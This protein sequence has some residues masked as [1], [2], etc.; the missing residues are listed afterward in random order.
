M[1]DKFTKVTKTGYGKRLGN[2]LKG[3]LVGV[4]LFFASFAVLYWNEGR[5][6]V[7][8]IAATATPIDAMSQADSAYEGMLVSATGKVSSTEQIGDGLY[9]LPGDYLVVSRS[10][11]MFAWVE[12]TS[13]E[14]ETEWGGSETETTTYDYV[15]KWTSMPSSS[16]GFEYPEDHYNPEMTIENE[17]YSVE[18]GKVGT[19]ELD[20]DKIS[21]AG[22]DSLSLEH[23][24]LTGVSAEA[25]EKEEVVE[26]VG[27]FTY[28]ELEEAEYEYEVIEEYGE[29][30]GSDE[31]VALVGDYI[32]IGEGT[33]NSPEV[34]DTRVSYTALENNVDMTVYGKQSGQKIVTHVDEKTGKS[35]YRMF[36]G[37]PEEAVV[38]M[39]GEYKMMLWVFRVI[40]FLMMWFGLTS[41]LAPISVLLDVA[42]FLGSLSRGLV[43]VVTFIVSAILS[44]VTI[45]VSMILHNIYAVIVAVV[46]IVGIFFWIWKKKGK[47]GK[48]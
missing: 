29:A 24:M 7:S 4:L 21:L 23:E 31:R 13:T 40:G 10:V 19:Y 17:T 36:D 25:G 15:K 16:S 33:L 42:P 32:F 47:K 5:V 20:M 18:T 2:S 14:S 43:S 44:I 45:V 12:E 8:E 26:E 9:L 22:F 39:H 30:V 27:E 41:L 11:E 3:I 38:A 28:D 35:L 34:G 6:D 48:K 1:T 37:T 46:V